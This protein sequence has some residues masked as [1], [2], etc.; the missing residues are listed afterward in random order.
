MI[1]GD[2][3][4]AFNSVS[5]EARDALIRKPQH[6][7]ICRVGELTNKSGHLPVEEVTLP[8]RILVL[9]KGCGKRPTLAMLTFP[10]NRR[11]RNLPECRTS[12]LQSTQRLVL[13]HM[14]KDVLEKIIGEVLK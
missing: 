7:F 10:D 14:L 3:P 4:T 9:A 2:V 12:E 5:G 6:S 8:V 13:L 11:T 1:L